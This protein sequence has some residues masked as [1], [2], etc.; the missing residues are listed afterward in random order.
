MSAVRATTAPEAVPDNDAQ[1]MRRR[2]TAMVG[3]IAATVLPLATWMG[4]LLGADGWTVFDVLMLLFFAH[5]AIWV[6]LGLWNAVIGLIV[7]RFA[8][9]SGRAGR[10]DH[11]ERRR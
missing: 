5:N 2:R 6:A 8:R 10:P 4:A 7:S 11:Q 9:R 1:A 3:L